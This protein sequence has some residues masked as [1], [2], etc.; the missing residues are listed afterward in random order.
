VVA[1]GTR[2]V[3]ELLCPINNDDQRLIPNTNVNVRIELAVRAN[4]LIVPRGAILFEGSQHRSVFVVE[5]GTPDSILHKREVLLGIPDSTRYEV[6]SGVK[7]GDVVAILGNIVP[8]D[9][10]K[11]RVEQPE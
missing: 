1:H 6:L 11:V 7:E 2:T 10:M 3:G 5:S 4:V 8:K 9:G